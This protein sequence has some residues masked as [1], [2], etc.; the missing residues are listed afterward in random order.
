M[1]QIISHKNE[2]IFETFITFAPD[3]HENEGNI[4]IS[5]IIPV[6][7]VSKYVERCLKSIIKQTY[8]HFE[9]ILVDDASPDDSFQTLPTIIIVVVIPLVRL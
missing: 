3:M 1:P 8:N 6:Y 9:C 4:T 7:N 2:C 5:L